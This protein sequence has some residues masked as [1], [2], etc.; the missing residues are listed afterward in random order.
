MAR[1]SIV[2]D[3]K[4]IADNLARIISRSSDLAVSGVYYNAEDALAAIPAERADLVLMD[5]GLPR[6]DGISC[7]VKIK[8]ICPE[9]KFLMFTIFDADQKLFDAL[10]FGANG[11]ILKSDG[12]M[13][14]MKAIRE[15]LAGGAPMSR[16]IA[17]K[18]LESLRLPA[19]PKKDGLAALTPKQNEV[20]KLLA[21]GLQN[22]EVADRM[23]ITEGTVKAHNYKIYKRLQVD[24][25]VEAVNVYLKGS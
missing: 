13:G 5:I 12:S 15:L 4:D 23:G 9:L 25:R 14:T 1:I 8:E 16:G 6:M 22:I 21:E 19:T 3:R 11:Y 18:V 2:E 24:N 17:L 20:L 7:M 10:R